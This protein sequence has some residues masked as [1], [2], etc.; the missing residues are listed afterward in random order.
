MG[1]LPSSQVRDC[2]HPLHS[3]RH[4]APTIK[5]NE[6][7]PAILLD[8]GVDDPRPDGALLPRALDDA[9]ALAEGEG[10]KRMIIYLMISGRHH[11]IAR[12]MHMNA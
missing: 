11:V 12:K 7:Q 6:D 10:S 5:E 9:L 1:H 8:L 4:A 3:H 2:H